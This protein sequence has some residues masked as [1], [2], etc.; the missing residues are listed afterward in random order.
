M[1]IRVSLKNSIGN[2]LFNEE[3][4][5]KKSWE[6]IDWNPYSSFVP[7]KDELIVRK[8]SYAEEVEKYKKNMGEFFTNAYNALND[9]GKLV[10][11]FTHKSWKAWET[12]LY[13]IYISGFKVEGFYPF[14]SEH[15][16]RSVSMQGEPKLNRTIV[17]MASK[18]AN[19]IKDVEGDV[20][21]FCSKVYKYLNYAKIMPREKIELWEK[22]ITLMA[23]SAAR[24]T[25]LNF[26]N[27]ELAFENE[28]LPKGI[29]F[30]LTSLLKILGK[31]KEMKNLD[32]Q[33]KTNLLL[34]MLQK[35]YGRVRIDLAKHICKFYNIPLDLTQNGYV[36]L[37]NPSRDLSSIL[38]ILEVKK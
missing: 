2:Y 27:K 31:E 28:I 12:I 17:I 26:K 38:E 20:F 11:W 32:A 16:T 4:N 36:K 33:D 5:E 19:E 37:K 7:R 15:P 8:E 9:G 13:S 10:L 23:A 22:A 14:V 25:A 35:L 29:V 30:G 3:I 34:Y 21:H 1:L 6:Y 24:L 18:Q